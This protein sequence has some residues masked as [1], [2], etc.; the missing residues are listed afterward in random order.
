MWPSSDETDEL[1]PSEFAHI[2]K[3]IGTYSGAF[4]LVDCR[5]E[6]E[7]EICRI[8]GAILVPLSR[9]VFEASEKL[10][11]KEVP[12]VVYCHHGQRSGKATEFL[13]RRGYANA[14]KL[15]GGIEAWSVEVD[16]EV[17]RY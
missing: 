14:F 8:E 1:S 5:E 11:N 7:Y 3:D 12:I 10:P 9:L 6:D 2:L 4:M 15:A 13:R 17:P 16:P